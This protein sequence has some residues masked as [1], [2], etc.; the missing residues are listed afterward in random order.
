M[1]NIVKLFGGTNEESYEEVPECIVEPAS[2]FSSDEMG[3]L[4]IIGM[5]STAGG[6]IKDFLIG[7]GAQIFY[8]L[9]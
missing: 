5:Q 4:L 9:W 2:Q 8:I 7:G 6:V 1:G 3:R